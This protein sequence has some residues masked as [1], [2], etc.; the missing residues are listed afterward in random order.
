M[1]GLLLYTAAM[2]DKAFRLQSEHGERLIKESLGDQS[3]K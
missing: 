2:A 1:R 3:N